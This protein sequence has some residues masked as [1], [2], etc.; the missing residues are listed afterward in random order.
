MGDT[1]PRNWRVGSPE[2]LV[3]AWEGRVTD[4]SSEGT[5]NVGRVDPFAIQLCLEV[6]FALTTLCCSN[7]LG[8]TFFSGSTGGLDKSGVPHQRL[9]LST[10]NKT[11][12][13]SP[14]R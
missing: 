9:L 13:R 1:F 8:S 11:I 12:S 14:G 2:N 3:R 5:Q 4:C 6:A 7:F 10:G